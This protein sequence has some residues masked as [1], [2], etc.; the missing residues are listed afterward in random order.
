MSE[1]D[2][3]LEEKTGLELESEYDRLEKMV[4]G[5]YDKYKHILYIDKELFNKL[6]DGKY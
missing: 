4:G 2:L 6:K 3:Y 1:D 5:V